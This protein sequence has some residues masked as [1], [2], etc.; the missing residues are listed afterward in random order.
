[1]NNAAEKLI[2]VKGEKPYSDSEC[3]CETQE[4]TICSYGPCL[5]CNPEE[6]T[7][8]EAEF[9]ILSCPEETEKDDEIEIKVNMKNPFP[10]MKNYTVYSYVYE[11]NKPVSLGLDEGEWINTWNAN[12]QNVS[13]PGNSSVLLTLKNRIAEDTELGKY[14]MRVRIWLDGKKHDMTKDIQIKEPAKP[15][16]QTIQEENKTEFNESEV[17]E[18]ESEI[19]L[20]TGRI[21]SKSEENWLS[22][23]IESVINFFKNLFNL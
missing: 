8:E 10:N 15:V 14:K 17:S 11:G 7:E 4:T 13:I 1:S 23:F 20:P 21:V 18:P 2:V 22:A 6:K 16:N 12:R 19:N 5:P 3:S 9:E